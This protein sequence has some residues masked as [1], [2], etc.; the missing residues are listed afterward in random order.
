MKKEAKNITQKPVAAMLKKSKQGGFSLVEAGLVLVLVAGVAVFAYNA[1]RDN[2]ASSL[3]Q[4]QA[5]G[6]VKLA[7]SVQKI[8][9]SDVNY[10]NVDNAAVVKARIVPDDFRVAG[11]ADIRN[12]WGG[13]ITVAAETVGAGANNKVAIT[14]GTVP[15]VACADFINGIA[16]VAESVGAAAADA[17]AA[18]TNAK[19]ADGAAVKASYGK[20]NSAVSATQCATFPDSGGFVTMILN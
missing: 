20:L 15:R 3:A 2:Q 8:F 12:R 7:A 18:T 4:N 6:A 9:G 17:G 1:F 14:F 5:A 11:A 16:S 10:T 13:P 19:A